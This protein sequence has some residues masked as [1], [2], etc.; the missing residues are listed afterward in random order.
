VGGRGSNSQ[1]QQQKQ[2]TTSGQRAFNHIIDCKVCKVAQYHNKYAGA[3]N[4]VSVSKK[5]HHVLCSKNTTTWGISKRTVE[6]EQIATE[7][8]AVNNRSI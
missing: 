5:A 6:M 7:N 1:Q 3:C 4:K 2:V 8:I